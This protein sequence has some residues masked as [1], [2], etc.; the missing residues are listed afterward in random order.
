MPVIGFR[1]KT[2][3]AIAVVLDDDAQFVW[4][5]EVSLVDP[6]MPATAE[7]YHEVMELP[8]SDAQVAVQRSV[9]AIERVAAN[10]IAELAVQYDIGAI[11]V[12]GAPDKK[13]EK[14]GNFHIRAHAA[15]GVLFRHVLEVG[16]ERNGLPCVTLNEKAMPDFRLDG[17]LKAMG[18]KAGAPWRADERAAATAAWA[19]L[20]SRPN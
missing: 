2:G 4:R 20:R 1:A 15:E 11:G 18:K 10:A 5:G 7:P 12:V 6:R 19:A 8:W 16:A 13:L 9:K 14:L 17:M 3:K